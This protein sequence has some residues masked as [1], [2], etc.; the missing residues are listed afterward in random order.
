[1]F[2]GHRPWGRGEIKFLFLHVT[3]YDHMIRGS[4]EWVSLIT[5]GHSAKLGGH[6]PFQ[7]VTWPYVTTWLE[8]Y[9]T[10]WVSFP[11]YKS[12][13]CQVWWSQALCKKKNFAFSLS[14]DLTWVRD[15]RVMWHYG[16][17]SFII[18]DYPAKFGDHRP[19]ARGDIKVSICQVILRD[20]RVSRSGD[21]IGEFSSS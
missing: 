2:V 14:R 7:F 1:M 16:W 13:S 12:P 3:S 5:N 17:V 10:L 21:I 19:F 4:Y 11:H 6:W 20:H 15:Q 9:M 8:G 18:N